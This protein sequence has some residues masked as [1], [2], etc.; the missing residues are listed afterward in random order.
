MFKKLVAIEPVSLIPS[1]EEELHRYAGEITLHEDV[2]SGDGEIIRRIG[3]AD[4]VLV[5]YIQNQPSCDRELPIHPV[6][7]HVLQPLF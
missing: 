7:W 6:H 3:D 5:S 1:A 2:P 4:A